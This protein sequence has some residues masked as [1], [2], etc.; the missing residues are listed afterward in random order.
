MN[1]KVLLGVY[2][3]NLLLY[4][5]MAGFFYAYSVSVMLGLDGVDSATA[6]TAMQA[7]N[8]AVRNGVFLM[9]YLLPP[10]LSLVLAIGL[11]SRGKSSIAAIT[12]AAGMIYFAGTLLPTTIVNVPMNDA[13]AQIDIVSGEELSSQ[14]WSDYSARWTTWNTTRACISIASFLTLLS[15][16]L[17]YLKKL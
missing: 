16:L 10:I 1:T 9:T 13:L 5:L 11:L 14:T 12:F 17:L 6:I 7:I 3:L 15:S 8:E 2:G 4:G